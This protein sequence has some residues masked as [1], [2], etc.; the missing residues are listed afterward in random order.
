[1]IITE[2]KLIAQIPVLCCYNDTADTKRVAIL[3]H[4]F[5]SSKEVFQKNGLLEK[6]ANP[7]FLR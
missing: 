5:T 1:M 4:G 6:L 2:K 3:A 7:D